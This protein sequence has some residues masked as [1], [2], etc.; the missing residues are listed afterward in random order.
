MN[1]HSTVHQLIICSTEWQAVFAVLTCTFVAS[2]TKEEEASRQESHCSRLSLG[3]VGL[4]VRV[5]VGMC[6]QRELV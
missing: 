4:G 1:L 6:F 3:G 2:C 5:W